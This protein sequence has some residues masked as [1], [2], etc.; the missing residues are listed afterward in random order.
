[1]NQPTK[2]Q[3][4]HKKLKLTSL[5]LVKQPFL[6]KMLSKAISNIGKS[7][8]TTKISLGNLSI[9]P[10]SLSNIDSLSAPLSHMHS[11][12]AHMQLRV[13]VPQKGYK[14]RT[15]FVLLFDRVIVYIYLLRMIIQSFIFKRMKV[16]IKNIERG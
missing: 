8:L 7:N 6:S 15:Y 4:K 10:R 13:K 14:K 5:T 9:S 3:S 11:L 16:A 2:A 1:V 12:I